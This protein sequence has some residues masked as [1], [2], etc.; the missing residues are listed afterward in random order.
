MRRSVLD[1]VAQDAADL[2]KVLGAADRARLDQH[3]EGIRSIERRLDAVATGG[4]APMPA[5]AGCGHPTAPADALVGVRGDY[6]AMMEEVNRTM[7]DLVAVAFACDITRVVT[8]EFAQPAATYGVDT[9]TGA[10]NPSAHTVSHSPP[11]DPRNHLIAVHAMKQLS[12]FVQAL[13]AVPEGAGKLLDSCGILATTDIA[14]GATHSVKDLPMIVVGRAG[15]LRSGIHYRSATGENAIRVPLTI[16][17]AVGAPLAEH[18]MVTDSL[19]A[20]LS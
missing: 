15:G 16:A 19:G 10:K 1:L 9:I 3:L 20:I 6:D 17:R 12:V 4:G 2:Q 18:G 11:S 13:R 5:G 14:E 7:S 8:Y